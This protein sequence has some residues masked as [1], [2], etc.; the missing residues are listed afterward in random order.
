VLGAAGAPGEAAACAAGAGL[1]AVAGAPCGCAGRRNVMKPSRTNRP[2][3][4]RVPKRGI[5]FVLPRFKATIP[6]RQTS[7]LQRSFALT[8]AVTTR[9]IDVRR[10]LH[11]FA[12]RAAVLAGRRH[13]RTN[14]M[15]TLLRFRGCHVISPVVGS[16]NARFKNN[17]LEIRRNRFCL[18]R[19]TFHFRTA[20]VS[21]FFVTAFRPPFAAAP[22]TNRAMRKLSGPD[23]E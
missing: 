8:D 9:T 22:S 6:P 10:F 20:V 14:R 13:A 4:N 12:L 11:G 3:D 17:S 19:H 21:G 7:R 2:S 16:K 23:G 1:S 5:D 18:K 15:R